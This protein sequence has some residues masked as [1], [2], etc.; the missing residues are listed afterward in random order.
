LSSSDLEENLKMLEENIKMKKDKLVKIKSKLIKDN[1]KFTL[2]EEKIEDDLSKLQQKYKELQS[3]K[4]HKKI[5]PS[6]VE[7]G[8]PENDHE[9]EEQNPFG[10]IKIKRPEHLWNENS[11]RRRFNLLINSVNKSQSLYNE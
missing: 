6:F 11:N 7:I 4:P 1:L 3:S 8:A 9:E 5:R 2:F 10:K